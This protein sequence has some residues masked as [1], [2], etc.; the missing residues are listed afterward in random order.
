MTSQKLSIL[1]TLIP[2]NEKDPHHYPSN[3]CTDT[4]LTP[5]LGFS[6]LNIKK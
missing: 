6:L 2:F 4:F 1:E 3:N 5:I